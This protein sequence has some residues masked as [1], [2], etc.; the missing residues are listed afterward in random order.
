MSW[1][2]TSSTATAWATGAIIAA[3]DVQWMTAG[4]GIIH[5]EMPKGD[6]RGRHGGLPALGQPA[7]RAQD[8]GAALPGC[9][10]RADPGGHPGG[11]RANQ[12]HLRPGRAAPTAR[13]AISSSSPSTWTSPCRRTPPSSIRPRADH[14]VLAYV[15]GGSGYFCAEKK[16]F[17]FEAE[18]VNYFD[19]GN[20]AW[21]ANTTLVLFDEGD[22]VFV[23]TGE[24]PSASCSSQANRSASRLPGTARLS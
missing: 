16:P 9:E 20:P 13:C 2:E 22:H 8:D 19:M 21:S 1:P 14:T 12:G 4:S 10:G 17:T 7:G 5:Q 3:G 23:H 24:K 15:I 6:A 11:R 18:G